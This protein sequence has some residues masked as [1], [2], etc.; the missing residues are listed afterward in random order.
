MNKTILAIIK[1][2]IKAF[3]FCMTEKTAYILSKIMQTRD[4]LKYY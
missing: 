4:K 1:R 2:L 3:I